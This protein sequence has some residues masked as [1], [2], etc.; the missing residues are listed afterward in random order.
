MNRVKSESNSNT[1]DNELSTTS[2][3][4]NI[5][6]LNNTISITP[7]EFGYVK[8]EIQMDLIMNQLYK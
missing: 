1:T 7:R 5:N 4:N 3:S 8:M 6:D 2:Y